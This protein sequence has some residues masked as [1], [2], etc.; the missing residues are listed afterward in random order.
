MVASIRLQARDEAILKHIERYRLTTASVLHESL[1]AG[2]G[3]DAVTSTLRR[4]RR[5]NLVASQE[6][7]PPRQRYYHLTA[8]AARLR[9]LPASY[10]R[11][12]GEQ[13]LPT[14]YAILRF[15]CDGDEPREV[16]RPGEFRHM[17]ADCQASHL[18]LEPYYFDVDGPTTRLGLLVVDLGADARRIVR[19]FRKLIG[20]RERVA[21]FRSL[22]RDDAFVITIL[23]AREA[24]KGA[25]VV[26]RQ[27][28]KDL[29]CRIRV[30]V[31]PSFIGVL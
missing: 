12:L 24:K 21:G 5:G 15:C 26:A 16:M 9:G 6:L 11:P 4:L 19:K 13:A 17:F 3:R 18:P 22:I 28:A 31:V 10:A 29:S 20:Q 2:K 30:E 1:F 27:R 14:R 23:T 25:I 7:A 8:Q